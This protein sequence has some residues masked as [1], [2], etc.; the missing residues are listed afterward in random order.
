MAKTALEHPATASGYRRLVR[1]RVLGFVSTLVLPTIAIT[2]CLTLLD[3]DDAIGTTVL[4]FLIG[5][6]AA[7]VTGLALP[8]MPRTGRILRCYPWQA[9]PCRYIE[10]SRDHLIVM[11]LGPDDQA[12]VHP[13]PFRCDLQR[14]HNDQPTVIWFAGDPRCGGVASPVGGHYPQRV[15]T[16]DSPPPS[17]VAPPVAERAGLARRGRYLRRW[18]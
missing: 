7:L 12:V 8:S 4:C 14:K 13:A 5:V 1:R 18:C 11:Q 15:I 2:A 3:G 9:Y 17:A 6:T 10:R 16:K